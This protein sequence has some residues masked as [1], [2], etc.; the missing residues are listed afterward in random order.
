[1]N[2]LTELVQRISGRHQQLSPSGL[3]PELIER[4]HQRLIDSLARNNRDALALLLA[5]DTQWRCG[6]RIVSGRDAVIDALFTAGENAQA[7]VA[8][9][10]VSVHDQV[11]V[12]DAQWQSD[13]AGNLRTWTRSCI[14]ALRRGYWQVV[15]VRDLAFDQRTAWA[16]ADVCC[17]VGNDEE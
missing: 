14:F 13:I 15:S 11:A 9:A 5:A 6:K 17:T 3:E 7:L 2:R 10:Q 4:L 16:I 8:M 1:M 12:V